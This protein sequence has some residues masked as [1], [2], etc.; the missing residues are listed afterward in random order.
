[1]EEFKLEMDISTPLSKLKDFEAKS[2]RV[3]LT[4]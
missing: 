4:P 3:G 1:V 2:V